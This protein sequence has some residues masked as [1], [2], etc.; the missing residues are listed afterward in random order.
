M[1]QFYFYFRHS[2]I[3]GLFSFVAKMLINQSYECSSLIKL[4]I[5]KSIHLEEALII[6][7][8]CVDF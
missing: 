4:F 8:A 2:N 6:V 3:L 7:E 1:S 5:H